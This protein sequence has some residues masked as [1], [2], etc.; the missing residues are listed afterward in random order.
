MALVLIIIANCHHSIVDK[1]EDDLQDAAEDGGQGEP[2]VD[3]IGSGMGLILLLFCP[4]K[5]GQEL[6]SC[7]DLAHYT[8]LFI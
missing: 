8:K 3:L 5:S 2:Q 6:V 7:V 1:V 4:D